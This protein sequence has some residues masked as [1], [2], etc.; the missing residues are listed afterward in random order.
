MTTNNNININS[1]TGAYQKKRSGQAKYRPSP[2]KARQFN[3]ELRS[4]AMAA[5]IALVDLDKN[6]RRM[7]DFDGP[8]DELEMLRVKDRKHVGQL[9][10]EK[11]VLYVSEHGMLVEL[12]EYLIDM[13]E[14]EVDLFERMETSLSIMAEIAIEADEKAKAPDANTGP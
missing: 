14:Y 13:I 3:S 7:K 6:A 9:N 10:A 4:S 12:R 5:G 11:D 8:A 2:D 1:G